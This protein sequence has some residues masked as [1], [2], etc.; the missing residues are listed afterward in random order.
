MKDR[1]ARCQIT[2]KDLEC[3]YIIS[4]VESMLHS[5]ILI[6]HI[7]SHAQG[8][9]HYTQGDEQ[10]C[11]WIKH[12]VGQQLSKSAFITN[13]QLRNN[14]YLSIHIYVNQNVYSSNAN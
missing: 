8:V 14:Y 4:I 10:V 6:M 11:K 7:Q 1:I 3:S 12:D 9:H 13:I 2:N 5:W